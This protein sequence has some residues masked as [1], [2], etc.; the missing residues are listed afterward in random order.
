M[1]KQLARA[2]QIEAEIKQR[3]AQDQAHKNSEAFQLACAPISLSQVRSERHFMRYPLF[4][5]DKETRFEPIE[6]KSQDGTRFV[7][8]TA[9]ATYGMATQRDA[10][11]LRYAI[12]KL[13]EAAFLSKGGFTPT[14]AF[15]RYEVLTAIGKN[16]H[17]Q[18]YKWLN[19]AIQRLA[20]TGYET[21]IFSVS[22][23]RKHHGPL[24]TFETL[25]DPETKE[26]K[27]IAV[28]FAPDIVAAIRDRGVLAVSETV[29]LESGDLK[30]RLLE[31]IQVHMG[32]NPKWEITLSE[33]ARLCAYS[34]PLKY[35]KERINRSEL[36]YKVSY[37]KG[38]TGQVA[39]FTQPTP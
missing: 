7:T 14:V 34:R 13:T 24:A 35:L 5:T 15:T 39:S 2:Q 4:A 36:P 17:Q 37:R 22:P 38:R 28:H 18:D 12:S 31:V 25:H 20:N 10:D 29:L 11:V 16:D 27:G 9:N 32:E 19:G 21:N 26:I 6:Y 3:D 30:K 23:N 33:L 1:E 8:V